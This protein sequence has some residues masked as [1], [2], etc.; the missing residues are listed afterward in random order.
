MSEFDKE[1]EREKL[2]EKFAKDERKRRQTQRM[3]ELLLK[4]ATMTN[5]HCDRCGDPIFRYDGEEFCPTCASEEAAG[6]AEV[7]ER[8]TELETA[9]K[10]LDV[11]APQSD[12]V[13]DAETGDRERA[14][15]QGEASATEATNGASTTQPPESD[16]TRSTP[17]VDQRTAPASETT[18]PV[19]PRSGESGSSGRTELQRALSTAA[20]N[21]AAAEDP[22]TAKAW[23]EAARE[24]AEALSALDR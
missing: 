6:A 16:R 22:H 13:A 19:A 1:A 5:R 21:A 8:D 14:G 7:P 17:R 24:A 9:E 10:S 15:A 12:D 2:R 3:S 11:E 20:S 18:Q 4:G 23:L